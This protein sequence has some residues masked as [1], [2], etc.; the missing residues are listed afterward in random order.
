M[1]KNIIGLVIVLG[2]FM[3][4]CTKKV[5][6][7]IIFDQYHIILTTEYI[8][9]EIAANT[10]AGA[11]AIKQYIQEN[12]TGFAGSIIIAKIQLETGMD[13]STFAT[14]NSKSI[15]RK[16][17]GSNKPSTDKFSFECG[18]GSIDGILQKI[19]IEEGDQEQYLNQM[20]FTDKNYL[21]GISTM[22][23]NKSESK[24][25]AKSLKNISC[26]TTAK[27]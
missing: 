19:S 26:A 9:Q 6:K 12:E 15:T 10:M 5:E 3:G 14:Y 4:G 24:N 21:Y 17:M 2:L 1:K 13:I 18:S 11:P 7:P 8:Y 22:T 16:I 25:L 27:E 20:F 23:T